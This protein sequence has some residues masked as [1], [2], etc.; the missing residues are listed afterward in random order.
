[1]K[2]AIRKKIPPVLVK[3]NERRA[4]CRNHDM[5]EEGPRERRCLRT[6]EEMN[7]ETH[8][9]THTETYTNT[10]THIEYRQTNRHTDTHIDT[11]T[12]RHTHTDIHTNT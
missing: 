2:E 1:M 9:P 3:R 7:V 10:D 5:K 11:Q 4:E 6:L 8:I 12:H